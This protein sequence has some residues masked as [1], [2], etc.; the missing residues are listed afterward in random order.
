MKSYRENNIDKVKE[1]GASIKEKLEESNKSYSKEYYEKNKDELNEK[2]RETGK[3]KTTCEVCGSY[4]RKADQS[5]HN[6]TQKHINA[7]TK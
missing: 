2:R 4:F 1:Y 7:S 3:I 5:K 6:K